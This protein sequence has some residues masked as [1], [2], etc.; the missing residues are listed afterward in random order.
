MSTYRSH[1]EYSS[2]LA[3]QE[4]K[5][6][7]VQAVGFGVLALAIIAI[8]IF[9]GIPA[10]IKGAV[11]LGELNNSSNMNVQE[12]TIPPAAPQLLPLT[13]ATSSA[14][15]DVEGY[16]E[17]GSF[18]TLFVN[19]SKVNESLIDETGTFK[20]SG[21]TISDGTSTIYAEA[22]DAAGNTSSPST[23]LQVTLYQDKPTLTITY[24]VEGQQLYGLDNQQ[25]T[26]EGKTE[27]TNRV[28]INDRQAVVIG[29]GTF[30][31]RFQLKEG[32]NEITIKV[33]DPAG[34][35]IEETI[36]VSY[37]P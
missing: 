32:G 16:A 8:V 29:D 25:I 12:D 14:Q 35:Q 31:H 2:R 30:K 23:K 13:E 5:R 18:V 1:K 7:T 9:V 24:P 4:A 15:I 28:S 21:I 26:I 34:N 3:R 17:V 6:F 10:F 11:F 37:Q 33:A 20:F 19:G 22:T 36:T 27:S